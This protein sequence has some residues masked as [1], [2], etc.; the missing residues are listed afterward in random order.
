MALISLGDM[1][2]N[3]MLR[4]QTAT[5]KL[6]ARTAATELATG[7]T[8][9]IA[10]KLHGDLNRTTGIETSL[11]RLAGY[12]IATN[13]AALTASSMQNVLGQ[14]DRLT[15]DLGPILLN[16]GTISGTNTM[17]AFATDVHERLE[18]TL[19][20]LNTQL[21][22]ATLFAGVASDGPAVADADTILTA[23]EA[24]ITGA[25]AVTAMDIETTVSAWFD[26][27]AGFAVIGY[28]GGD[29][30]SPQAVSPND[31]AH[32]PITARDPAL[33]DT[34]KSLALVALI[35][36]GTVI[37]D[38]PTKTALTLRAGEALLQSQT[39]RAALAG[40]LGLTEARIDQAAIR[41]EA[42]RSALQLA[43]SD[44][45]SVDPYE[46]ATRMEATQ[47]QLETLYSITA[48]LSR[49]SLVD[50]LR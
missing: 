38:A 40:K 6:D 45:L 11:T 20:A 29:A 48:R 14:I 49:L 43:Q 25:G 3:F 2:H 33:R 35:D 16:A 13:D 22:G 18:A 37:P 9:D 30:K 28:L 32:L 21:G 5:L 24:A 41:N 36:R 31:T 42:E 17:P 34:L 7:R 10:S 4:R 23:L 47:N 12:K 50:F 15:A 44:L 8:T 1:A 26:D 19:S 39:D 27:P 46:A